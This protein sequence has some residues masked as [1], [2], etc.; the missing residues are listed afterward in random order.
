[1]DLSGRLRSE[2]ELSSRANT[3]S[4][5]GQ[6][7]VVTSNEGRQVVGD[8]LQQFMVQSARS[9]FRLRSSLAF[10]WKC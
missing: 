1:M 4:M 5:R 2:R 10:P 8:Q 9:K 6:S 7:V 3:A